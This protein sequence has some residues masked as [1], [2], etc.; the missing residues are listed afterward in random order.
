MFSA[1]SVDQFPHHFAA[2]QLFGHPLLM[3]VPDLDRT[4]YW[5]IIGG[6]PIASNGSIMTAPDVA[7]RLKAIQQRNGKVV[8]IDPRRTETASRADEHH[9]IRPGTD[10]YLLLAM[11]QT[12]FA[13][14]LVRPG[15]LADCTDGFDTLRDAV[16]GF[17]PDA[18]A[19]LT[20]L[21]AETIR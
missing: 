20:G 16:G 1:S 21:S 19:S 12:L 5:L 4:D 18:A 15:R 13:E 14:G 17:T 3:P 2:W 10:V 9:F 7:N 11:V 8:V 6:N